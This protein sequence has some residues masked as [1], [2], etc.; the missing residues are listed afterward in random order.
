[1]PGARAECDTIRALLPDADLLTG[2]GRAAILSRLPAHAILH[3]AGHASTDAADP[4]RSGLHLADPLPLTVADLAPF[5]LGDAR[6]AYL[7]ACRTAH[8][9]ALG[10]ADEAITLAT[11][12][13]LAGYQHVIGTLWSVQD[14]AARRIAES[15]YRGLTTATGPDVSRSAQALHDAT[16]EARNRWPDHPWLWAAH[17]H[18]GP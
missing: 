15:F 12:F 6:L 1:L 7:S 5:R 2:P 3:F 4:S 16:I 9:G 8:A 18:T 13:Q 11:A 14:N 17:T 10:L